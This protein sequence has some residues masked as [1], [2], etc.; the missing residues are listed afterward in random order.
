M[1]AKPTPKHSFGGAIGWNLIGSVVRVVTTLVCQLLLLRLLGPEPAGHFAVFLFIVG[2]GSIL[3]EG[4]MSVALARTPSLDERV[5][6]NAL[7]LILCYSSVVALALLAFTTSFVRLFHLP[8]AESYVPILAALNIIPLALT[9]VP[10]SVLKQQYRARDVQLVQLGAYVLG[11]ALIALPLAIAFKSVIVLITAFTVQT[12]A[13]LIGGMVVSHCPVLPH[14]RGARAIRGVTSRALMVNI[15]AYVNESAANVLSAHLLGPRAVGLYS[16]TF[17]LLRMPT[18]VVVSALHG[19]LLVSTAQ[20]NGGAASRN[21]FLSTLNVLATTVLAV[22]IVVFL[23]GAQ[24]V[25]PLLGDKWL[26]AVPV[27]S[28]VSLIMA[29]RLISNICGAVV[30][31]QGRLM[32]DFGAQIIGM[33]VIVSGSLL[34]RP[35]NVVVVAWIVFASTTIR[36]LMQLLTAMRACAITIRQIKHALFGPALLTMLVMLPMYWLGPLVAPAG[37]FLGLIAL[38][39]TAAG[40]LAVRIA[41]GIRQS[42]YAWTSLVLGRL[43]RQRLPLGLAGSHIIGNPAEPGRRIGEAP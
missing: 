40:L 27:L 9:S 5:V 15:A 36:A 28:V 34:L 41:I 24:I 11:F 16:T 12:V 1:T 37:N 6:R 43:R 38:G 14:W 3:S 13:G 32:F 20:D 33:V 23:C 10:I 4:G 19:P 25:Q 21:R 30:W 22:Y 42:P 8:A 39:T 7:F 26:D 35:D 29:A 2:L 17:N 31:G 18:D